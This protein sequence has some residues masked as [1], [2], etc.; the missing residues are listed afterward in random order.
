M[1]EGDAALWWDTERNHAKAARSKSHRSARNL[2][3]KI[4]DVPV[5]STHGAN[6]PNGSEGALVEERWSWLCPSFAEGHLLVAHGSG[7]IVAWGVSHLPPCYAPQCARRARQGRVVDRTPRLS[8]AQQAVPLLALP[9]G[10][11]C[12]FVLL[13]F[14]HVL[15]LG[16]SSSTPGLEHHSSPAHARQFRS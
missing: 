14:P 5:R 7:I 11:P 6:P 3:Q 15:S 4:F 12:L 13:R 9:A 10:P 8:D 16:H 1:S 2:C